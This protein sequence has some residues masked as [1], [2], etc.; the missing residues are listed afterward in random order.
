MTPVRLCRFGRPIANRF[1]YLI[2]RRILNFPQRTT[3]SWVSPLV[4]KKAREAR[5]LITRADYEEY[6]I[7]ENLSVYNQQVYSLMRLEDIQFSVENNNDVSTVYE[8][9]GASFAISIDSTESD[10]NLMALGDLDIDEAVEEAQRRRPKRR[11]QRRRQSRNNYI[12][13]SAF[14]G[15]DV[16][17][18]DESLSGGRYRRYAPYDELGCFHGVEVPST[19]ESFISYDDDYYRY[20]ED[21]KES[22]VNE[23]KFSQKYSFRQA[24]H[25]KN[26]AVR[27]V[28][29]VVSCTSF[30]SPTT[31]WSTS[32]L[33]SSPSTLWIS[34]SGS[35]SWADESVFTETTVS[36]SSSS[37]EADISSFSDGDSSF[38]SC[39]SE[40]YSSC[41][42]SGTYLEET[43][44]EFVPANK[45]DYS[46]TDKSIQVISSK[47]ENIQLN[48]ER[49]E[50]RIAD[51]RCKPAQ[52]L[53]Y[54][55]SIPSTSQVSHDCSAVM[56]TVD[57]L[58]P[59]YNLFKEQ[60]EL[61]NC[62]VDACNM[63]TFLQLIESSFPAVRPEC[64]LD[65]IFFD[66]RQLVCQK[67]WEE[68]QQE[69]DEM[70]KT[71]D[72]ETGKWYKFS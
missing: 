57:V 17:D 63:D 61:R 20:K 64:L 12:R 56:Q 23:Y 53:S 1:K 58:L 5:G 4:V 69:Q 50:H 8:N 40:D 10:F 71:I 11:Q 44:S 28:P 35:D 52:Y 42:A 14:F 7:Y 13:H 43:S 29:K 68:E 22:I 38:T 39:S 27:L 21:K 36:S 34:R 3:S 60:Q 62:A 19:D 25:P 30:S 16:P 70:N 66:Y 37:N 51:L 33:L 59:E 9:A 46:L 65:K 15:V 72:S 55:S 31:L 24:E 26:G 2:D 49:M 45:F 67:L 32:S 47:P 54:C 41:S 48:V 6:G 18:T